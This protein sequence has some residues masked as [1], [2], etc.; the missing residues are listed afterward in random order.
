MIMKKSSNPKTTSTKG[1]ELKMEQYEK[2]GDRVIYKNNQLIAF[3]KPSGVPVQADKTGDKSLFQLAEIFT[4]SKIY[5]IHRLDR[6]A[7][8]A[9]HRRTPETWRAQER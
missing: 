4:R 5:L 2:I 1:A 6:P 3:N 9:S 8:F 7:R